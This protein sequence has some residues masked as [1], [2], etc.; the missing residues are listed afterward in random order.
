MF[1]SISSSSSSAVVVVAAAAGSGCEAV[2]DIVAAAVGVPR[3]SGDIDM[4]TSGV[5]SC[6][7]ELLAE[8]PARGASRVLAL[9]DA[10][11]T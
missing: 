2:A 4:S 6:V 5:S 3:R 8:A 11:H 1:F 7:A 10:E 9:N